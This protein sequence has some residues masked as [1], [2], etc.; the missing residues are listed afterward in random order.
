MIALRSQRY[1]DHSSARLLRPT[2]N[3]TSRQWRVVFRVVSSF[4]QA[5]SRGSNR[6]RRRRRRKRRRRGDPP[7]FPPAARTTGSETA[8]NFAPAVPERVEG[9][10]PF[11]RFLLARKEKSDALRDN[12]VAIRQRGRPSDADDE[13]EGSTARFRVNSEGLGSR[14]VQGGE[15]ATSRGDSSSSR[16][17]RWEEFLL[18]L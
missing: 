7:E 8:C 13:R 12:R 15:D 4:N 1:C 6:Q 18:K 11:A 17:L 2:Q 14:A 9:T 3:V 5:S 10:R 16:R